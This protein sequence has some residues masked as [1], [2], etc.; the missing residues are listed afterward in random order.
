MRQAA[1]V[2]STDALRD[3][4]SALARFKSRAQD[5]LRTALMETRH[6]L[7]WLDKQLDAWRREAEKRHEIVLRCRS[8]L[9]VVRSAPENLRSAATEREID[10]RKAMARLREAEE[11][12]EAVRRWKRMLP[13]IVNEHELPMRRLSGFL[14]GDVQYA[15]ALLDNKIESLQAYMALAAP[16]A[17]AVG[18][19]PSPAPAAPTN[20]T[21]EQP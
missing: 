15:L 6:T 2:L 9:A 12:V 17:P 13:Q 8:E 7:D 11:K 4:R 14:E 10:L 21:G 19:S 5:G 16:E 3:L 1:R 18:L 20:S